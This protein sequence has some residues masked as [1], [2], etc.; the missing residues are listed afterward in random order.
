VYKLSLRKVGVH[1]SEG[2]YYDFCEKCWEC[3]QAWKLD[4]DI[5]IMLDLSDIYQVAGRCLPKGKT[6]FKHFLFTHSTGTTF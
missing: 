6:K 2:A 1:E 3:Y 4:R 5:L